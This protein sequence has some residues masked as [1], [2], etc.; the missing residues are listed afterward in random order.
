[1]AIYMKFGSIKGAVTTQGYK[2]WIELISFSWGVG[3]NIGTA[4]R[5]YSLRESSEPSISEITITK[6]TDVSSP[7]LFQEA[8]AGKMDTKVVIAFTT[9]T[10]NTV[11]DYLKYELTDIGVSQYGLSSG[12]EVPVETFALNFAKI[13][14]TFKSHDPGIS[15]TPET[16]GY[17]LTLMKVT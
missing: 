10:K 13:S 3:R 1:M 2:D 9:T 4:A 17:D 5:G 6:F 16:V 11:T 14:V 7:K 8:L 15:G 12:G